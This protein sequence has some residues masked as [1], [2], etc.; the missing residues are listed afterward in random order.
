MKLLRR[1]LEEMGAGRLIG[2]EAEKVTLDDLQALVVTDYEMN[3]R[4]SL[5]RVRSAWKHL[6]TVFGADARALDLTTDRLQRYVVDRRL[7]GAALATIQQEMA[8]LKRGFSLA[9]RSGRLVHRPAFPILRI[10]NARIGFFEEGDFRALCGHL[11]D[12]LVPMVTFAYLTGWRVASEVQ[13]LTWDRVDFTAQTVRLEQRTTKNGEARVF[14]FG[15]FP[16]LAALLKEQRAR[17]SL[18]VSATGEPIRWVFHRHGAQI[19][20]FRAAWKTACASAG[21]ASRIPHDLRRTAVRN[22][23]RAGVSR[24]VAMQL[25]GHKTEA[26]YRRY[27]IVAEADLREGVTKLAALTAAR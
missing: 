27:A 13:R 4:R 26:V 17:T 12:Y 3:G 9:I 23:E 16:A 24:S 11:P 14:P 20:D 2:P 22:L 15:T 19:K 25:T 18:L 1:R 21:L 7:E 5:Q 8:A 6:T 10:A